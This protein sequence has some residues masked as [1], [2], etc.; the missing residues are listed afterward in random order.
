MG[1][2]P[3]RFIPPD[4]SRLFSAFSPEVDDIFFFGRLL[5]NPDHGLLLPVFLRIQIMIS[6]FV[7]D[8][9]LQSD[10]LL[11]HLLR[12]HLIGYLLLF[13]V[14]KLVQSLYLLGVGDQLLFE[15]VNL[16]RFLDFFVVDF[17]FPFQ[18]G[19]LDSLSPL[20]IFD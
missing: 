8:I 1:L 3:Q 19:A 2:E 13:F 9:Q 16:H 10:H 14:L 15:Q 12:T 6:N 17:G 5:L 4:F 18:E 7:H 11:L 20:V